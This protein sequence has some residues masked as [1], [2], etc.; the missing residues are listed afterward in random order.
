MLQEEISMLDPEYPKG[1]L[2]YNRHVSPEHD[3]AY[4]GH[5]IVDE[6]SESY[7][8]AE[9]LLCDEAVN[10]PEVLL[11]LGEQCECVGV[12]GDEASRAFFLMSMLCSKGFAW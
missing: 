1:L 4:W 11:S 12:V 9:R 5:P 3:S 2:A 8:L 6:E 7:Q 10:L